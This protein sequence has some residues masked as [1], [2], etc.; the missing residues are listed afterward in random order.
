MLY[1]IQTNK[2]LLRL[3]AEAELKCLRNFKPHLLYTPYKAGEIITVQQTRK[4]KNPKT[5]P[6]KEPIQG[7]QHFLPLWIFKNYAS[8][9]NSF[10]SQRWTWLEWKIMKPKIC[11]RSFGCSSK[12]RCTQEKH[13]EQIWS[14]HC[15][16]KYK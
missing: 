5:K 11:A 10:V 16:W 13:L 8:L 6:K 15:L 4:S 3:I 12:T 9:F 14:G 1:R 7:K 2:W